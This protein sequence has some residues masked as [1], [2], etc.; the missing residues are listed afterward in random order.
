[1]KKATGSVRLDL[2]QFR[3]MEIFTQFSS[4]L[5]EATKYRLVYGQG[6]MR[7]LRQPQS[8][9]Y[10][11]HEQ[12]FLL[13]AAQDHI[14]QDIPLDDIGKFKAGMLAFFEENAPALCTSIDE[15]KVM[16]AENREDIIDIARDYLEQY[17]KS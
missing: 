6:L 11:L 15:K 12:V 16:E 1:M 2:A 9:P 10:T 17:K 8:S 13:V 3:E 14:F 5:D 4:D 7:M